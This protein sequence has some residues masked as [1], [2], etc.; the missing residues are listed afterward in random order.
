MFAHLVFEARK[1]M[2]MN[3][4]N[5]N[6]EIRGIENTKVSYKLFTFCTHERNVQ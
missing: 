1:N 5:E 4:E 3:F 6:N 2:R